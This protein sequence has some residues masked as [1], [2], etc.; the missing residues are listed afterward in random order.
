MQKPYDHLVLRDPAHIA[1][2]H[3]LGGLRSLEMLLNNH[4]YSLSGMHDLAEAVRSAQLRSDKLFHS[5]LNTLPSEI[6]C[7]SEYLYSL[8]VRLIVTSARSTYLRLKNRIMDSS[9]LLG[10]YD[11]LKK[12]IFAV[13]SYQALTYFNQ[14][15]DLKPFQILSAQCHR[16]S[17]REFVD[18]SIFEEYE[19]IKMQFHPAIELLLN[20]THTFDERLLEQCVYCNQ[21]IEHGKEVCS[22]NHELPRCCISMVQLPLMNEREC[23]RCQIFALDDIEMLKLALPDDV[24]IVDDDDLICPLCDMPMARPH[25]IYYEHSD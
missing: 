14:L 18:M 12:F 16:R 9:N 19:I 17:L 11:I 20:E 1:V 13:R 6:V 24:Q 22:E 7:T 10:E 25:S 2:C 23:T 15:S 8:K 5:Y 4:T 3:H 21:P